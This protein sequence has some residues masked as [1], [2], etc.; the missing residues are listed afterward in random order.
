MDGSLGDGIAEAA[1][2]GERAPRVCRAVV[3]TRPRRVSPANMSAASIGYHLGNLGELRTER[4]LTFMWLLEL[5]S[6]VFIF[7]C[8]LMF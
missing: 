1:E 5:N 2:E 4:V 7:M 6:C 3:V 8:V